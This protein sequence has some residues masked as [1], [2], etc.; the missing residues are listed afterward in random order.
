MSEEKSATFLERLSKRFSIDVTKMKIPE[1]SRDAVFSMLY[2]SVGKDSDDTMQPMSTTT[3]QTTTSLSTQKNTKDKF[4][5]A[6][7]AQ[8]I[9]RRSFS[10]CSRFKIY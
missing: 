2:P 5:S 4:V 7:N 10:V 3:H 9:W 6:Y 8:G 1:G